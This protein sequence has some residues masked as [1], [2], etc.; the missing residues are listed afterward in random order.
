MKKEQDTNFEP[1]GQ[2]V[3]EEEL[4]KFSD[5]LLTKFK[6]KIVELYIGDQYESLEF[7]GYSMPQNCIIYG[8]IMDVLDR[9]IILDCFYVDNMNE[10]RNNNIVYINAFQIRAMTE[11]N[12]Q[13]SLADIFLST[14]DASKIRKFALMI[15]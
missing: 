13:G 9:F 11:L 8:K 15:K 5:E 6:G 10:V 12:A 1:F 14:R 7:E 3:V 4:K 2:G